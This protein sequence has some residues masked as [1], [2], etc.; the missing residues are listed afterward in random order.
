MDKI[1]K[2]IK[3]LDSR[4]AQ[5]LIITME[6]IFKEQFDDLNIKKLKGY[7]NIFRVRVGDYRIIYKKDKNVKV[8]FVGRRDEKTYK[9]F[10]KLK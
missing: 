8:L 9:Q 7:K 1:L 10:N 3:S 4:N 5:K 2:T 6:L